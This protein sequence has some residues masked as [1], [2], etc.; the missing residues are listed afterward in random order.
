VTPMR[1]LY[2]IDSLGPGGAQRQLVT[3]V[4]S[5]DRT[6][7]VP[8]VAVYHPL[9]H[10]RPELDAAGVPLRLLAGSGGRDPRVLFALARLLARGRFDIVHSYLSTPGTLARLAAPFSGGARVV[11]SERNVDLGHSRVRL[12]LERLLCRRADALIANAT[13]VAREVQELVPAWSGRVHVVPNGLDW[14]E[15]TEAERTAGDDFRARHLGD[16]DI[17]IGVVGRVERQK[18]PDV[19]LGAL[20]LVPEP[21]LQRIKIVWVGPRIDTALASSVEARLTGSALAGRVVFLG[22]TRDTRSVYLGVDGILLCS[23]WEG[24]PNVVLEALAHGCPVIA[25]DVGDVRE[26]L[27]NGRGGWLVPSEDTSALARAISDFAGTPDRQLAQLGREVSRF[28]LANYSAARLAER[29]MA[30]YSDI[31]T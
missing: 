6:L 14:T 25:T 30:V 10:F 27:Q 22:E 7:V 8:E 21:L 29:T 26:L 15:P 28:V 12:A 19:L 18:A 3:L 17:L 4:R 2:L 11:V 31:L 1:V 13:S 24:F 20:E 5:L 9:S 23:R 16:A